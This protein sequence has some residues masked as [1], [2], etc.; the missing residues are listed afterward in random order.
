MARAKGVNAARSPHRW[1]RENR[2]M[3]GRA[4]LVLGHLPDLEEL[5]EILRD[6]EARSDEFRVKYLRLRDAAAEVGINPA[7]WATSSFGGSA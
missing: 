2:E 4:R 7:L 6:V 1:V 5:D 3:V